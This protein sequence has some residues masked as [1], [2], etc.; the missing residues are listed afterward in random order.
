MAWKK[1]SFCRTDTPMCTEV[2]GLD[3]IYVHIRN[4]RNP[5]VVA[6]FDREE[7]QSFVDGVR[8]GDFDLKAAPEL[9]A[10]EMVEC[11]Y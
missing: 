9:D 7:W 2:D 5:H 10:E 4:S 3:D 6:T 8:A 11:N 1:S